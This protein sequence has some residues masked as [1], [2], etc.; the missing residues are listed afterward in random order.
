MPERRRNLL[1]EREAS[2]HPVLD[3]TTRAVDLLIE[4]PGVDLGGAER[5]HDEARVRALGQVLGLG[6]DPP[7]AGVK[8]D[9]IF[10][11][12]AEVNFPR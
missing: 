3:L 2:I 4:D 10:L 6:D 1:A 12:N 9:R 7:C 11:R 8:A 5:G